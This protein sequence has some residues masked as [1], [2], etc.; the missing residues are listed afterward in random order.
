[1]APR[2]IRCSRT[3]RVGRPAND[4]DVGAHGTYSLNF[5]TSVTGTVRVSREVAM[6]TTP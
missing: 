2:P 5:R 1:M 3:S 4:P 6:R